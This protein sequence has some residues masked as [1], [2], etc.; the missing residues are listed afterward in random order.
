M[1]SRIARV[2]AIF[3]RGVGDFLRQV[4]LFLLVDVGYETTRQ[5]SSAR[6]GVALAHGRDLVR[7]ERILGLFNEVEVQ[8]WALARPW[9]IN[10]ANT[11]YFAL[12]FSISIVFITWLYFWRNNHYYF[13]RNIVFATDAIALLGYVSFPAAPP[14]LL[15]HFGFVDTLAH[16]ALSQQSP[17]VAA[18][19]N[20]FAAFPSIHT[21]Y[22]LIAGLGGFALFGRWEL[23]FASLSYPVLV[24]FAVVATGNHFW[25]DAVGGAMTVLAATGIA[26][27]LELVRPSLPRSTRQRLRLSPD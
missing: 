7:M 2:G 6:A 11:T 5:L 20:P 21:A 17:V 15:G 25:L 3:P 9:A 18:L 14:R 19:A 4:G 22:A 26:W 27:L 24:V 23:R 8:Q 12:S 16:G 13:V 1:D 10:L